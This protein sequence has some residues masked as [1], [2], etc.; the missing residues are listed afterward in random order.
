MTNFK[1]LFGTFAL[2]A[3][4]AFA[5]MGVQSLFATFTLPSVNGP[6]LGDQN[7]NVYTLADAINKQNNASFQGSL[8]AA[9]TNQA[10]CL[11][12]LAAFNNVITTASSTGVCLPPAVGG[13][14]LTINNAGANT[15]SVYGSATPFKSGTQDTI[16][17][18]TGTTAYNGMTTGLSAI[19]AAVDNGVWAC[20]SGS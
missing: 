19:C 8:V 15:L 1:K 17:G 7:V 3:V 9:G 20:Q 12:L 16:N 18:T 4:M 10:T 2:C 11:K 13:Q 6:S 14:R 5:G